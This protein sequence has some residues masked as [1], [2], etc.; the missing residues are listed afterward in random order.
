METSS[1]STSMDLE[2]PLAITTNKN[3]AFITLG[4]RR[5]RDLPEEDISSASKRTR[6][7]LLTTDAIRQEVE[8]MRKD[9]SLGGVKRLLQFLKTNMDGLIYDYNHD[10]TPKL[11]SAE[12][13]WQIIQ[14][15]S[16]NQPDLLLFHLGR[17]FAS[18]I[19][20]KHHDF[21]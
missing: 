10:Q 16:N 5:E 15:K 21:V 3:E 9:Q 20:D 4:K 19:Q 11:K 12:E 17:F 6:K 8:R 14:Q 13:I 18:L 7:S 1:S 2:G